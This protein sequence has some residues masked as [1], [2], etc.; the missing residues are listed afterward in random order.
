MKLGAFLMLLTVKKVYPA[1]RKSPPRRSQNNLTI[2]EINNIIKIVKFVI[3]VWN[4]GIYERKLEQNG[5]HK[6]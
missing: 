1:G 2:T 3:D 6:L 4:W 5:K